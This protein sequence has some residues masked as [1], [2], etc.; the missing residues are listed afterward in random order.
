MDVSRRVV[1]R[2][3]YNGT[4]R[5]TVLNGL[6]HAEGL[7]VDWVGRKLYWV[8]SF[9]DCMKVSELDGRYMRKLAEHCVDSNNTYCFD[10][11]RA[12]V[13]HPK[14]GYKTSRFYPRVGRVGQLTPFKTKV[15]VDA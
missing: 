12:I 10:N 9:L 4:G 13:V 2:I 15:D 6:P 3:F 11:P 7:A 1:E 8:D 14:Y 5:A